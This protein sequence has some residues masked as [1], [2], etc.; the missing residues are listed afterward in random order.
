MNVI[1]NL[2]LLVITQTDTT[3]KVVNYSSKNIV[4]YPKENRILLLDSAT[5]SYQDIEVNG[6]SIEYDIKSKT[7]RA[8]KDVKFLTATE[9]VDGITL[10]YSLD[11]KR[12]YMQKAN[13]TVENGFVNGQQIWLIKEKTLQILNGYY[14]TCDHNPPH[15]Y[16]FATQSKIL[17]DNTAIAQN[18]V[19]KIQGVPCAVA[20]FWFFPISKNR[21][22]G[23]LP[24]KFGQSNTEG[25]Y[26]KGV[27]YYLVI[28]DYADMTFM[29]DVME[30]KGFQPKIEGVYII[31]P[32]ARGQFL[33]SYIY[34]LDTKR[35]R[36]SFNGQHRSQFLFQS[37][38]EAYIDIQ[39]DQNYL[40]DYAENQA[41]WLKKEVYSQVSINRDFENIGRFSLT[42]ERRQDFDKKILD[43]KFPSLSINFYRIPLINNWSLTPGV[44]FTNTATKYDSSYTN[45]QEENIDVRLINGRFGISN[46][47]TFLGVF[48]LPVNLS[49]R[50]AR[51]EIIGVS[52]SKSQT[53]NAGT[54][55]SSSQTIFQALNVSEGIRYNQSVSYNEDTRSSSVLYNFDFNS[56]ITLY[57]LF[58]INHF[59]IDNILHRVT[60]NI[61]LSLI[62]AIKQYST[63]GIPRLDTNPQSANISFS[64][65]NFFQGKINKSNEKKDFANLVLQSNYDIKEKILSPLSVNSDLYLIN[66]NNIH[67][68]TNVGFTYPWQNKP[69][70]QARIS[71]LSINNSFNYTYTKRDTV[72]MQDLGLNFTL[73]HFY[74]ANSDG[75]SPLASQANMLNAVIS[76]APV[77]WRFDFSTNYNFIENRITDYSLSIWKDLHCWE[78]I[79]NINRFGS[80]WAYDFKVRIKKIPDVAVGKGLLGF[81]LPL[82]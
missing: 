9:K 24:F 20:P 82:Q 72:R 67:W 69:I 78:A 5:V 66:R 4:Y 39:S 81:V 28:N 74:T 38:L 7:L 30:K 14:T 62:P 42:T 2:V 75:L 48:D 59:G 33:G 43:W 80:Q 58:G 35:G 68:T 52:V 25:R 56:N 57:R 27:A 60:P 50:A 18:I 17:L 40:P 21:K 32:F 8:F 55:I 46:P 45:P 71:A 13:T 16:F 53:L 61:G 22:S 12:G 36:Y 19:M 76:V 23:L 6:D 79:V 54:G 77:G 34:E 41:Q 70:S 3:Q 10:Y 1:L 63:W 15:Y 11:S 65:N 44:S 26:A 51:D 47:R 31:N 37:N 64:L 29:L 73:N 49:F